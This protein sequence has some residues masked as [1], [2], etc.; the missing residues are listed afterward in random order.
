MIIGVKAHRCA[1]DSNEASF[2]IKY[3]SF[4]R[5]GHFLAHVE[6]EI[7]LWEQKNNSI[8]RARQSCELL[9]LHM[10][11]PQAYD[12]NWRS[13]PVS[14]DGS[15]TARQAVKRTLLSQAAEIVSLSCDVSIEECQFYP[16]NYHV[17]TVRPTDG[18][19]VAA[20]ALY[21]Q[22]TKD[23][24]RRY[25]VTNKNFA[26]YCTVDLNIFVYIDAMARRRS[27]SCLNQF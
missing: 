15:L 17:Q 11:L 7:S 1:T 26:S 21:N 18:A 4:V 24:T 22:R 8:V 12:Q 25:T 5:V 23:M 3:D 9:L 19:K 10:K 14:S 6:A 27:H 13:E 16:T 20:A 2:D